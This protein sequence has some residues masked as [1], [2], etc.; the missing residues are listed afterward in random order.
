MALSDVT[1]EKI[2]SIGREGDN[3]DR[4]SCLLCGGL[5]V[6]GST[7]ADSAPLNTLLGP[8]YS[9]EELEAKGIDATYDQVNK[10]L[11]HHHASEYFRAYGE[12]ISARPAK[13]LYLYMVSQS[14]P[15]SVMVDKTETYGAYQAWKDSNKEIKRFIVVLNPDESYTPDT[16]T[17]GYDVDVLDAVIKAQACAEQMHDEHGPVHFYME[18][19]DFD[20]ATGGDA[21][22]PRTNDAENV[23]LV[24][25]Q[26]LD[27]CDIDALHEGYAAVGTYV[28]MVCSKPTMA[29]SPAE[30]GLNYQG[31][32]QD[33]ALGKFV[34]YGFGNQPLAD[35]GQTTH[36]AF[37]DKSLVGVNTYS[38]TPGVYFDS[39]GTCAASTSD[40][41]FSE[42]NEVYNKANRLIYAAYAPLINTKVR[43]TSKGYLPGDTA[44]ALEERGN[45]IFRRMANNAEISAGVTVIDPQQKNAQ[46]VPRSIVTTRTLYVKWNMVPYGKLENISGTLGFTVSI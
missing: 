11:I 31:N 41:I 2:S 28:G 26:D 36:A 1:I 29:D 33:K 5:A 13:Q 44:K 24:I 43:V 14:T 30:V 27:V 45:A 25:A 15:M 7:D 39:S 42:L 34:R 8:F 17:D 6:V 35:W 32:I 19:R 18:C 9:V 46:N 20:A 12:N 23:T 21:T 40:Y 38:Q 22:D 37:K 4:I 16:A 3:T 10:T